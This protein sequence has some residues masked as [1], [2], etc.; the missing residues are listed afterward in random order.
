VKHKDHHKGGVLTN[1]WMAIHNAMREEF[2]AEM[3]ERHD[4]DL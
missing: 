4:L 1:G 2:T 3:L